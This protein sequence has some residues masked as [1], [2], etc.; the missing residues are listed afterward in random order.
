MWWLASLG[1][2]FENIGHRSGSD[3]LKFISFLLSFPCFKTSQL[4]FEIAYFFGQLR[5]RRQ[6][7]E[8]LFLKIYGKPIALGGVGHAGERLRHIKRRFEC[9]DPTKYFRNHNR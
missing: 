1:V 3:S 6:C 2:F 9:G 7:G 4:C 5:L 8:N